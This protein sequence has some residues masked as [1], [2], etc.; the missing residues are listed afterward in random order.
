MNLVE[1]IRAGFLNAATQTRLILDDVFAS[2]NSEIIYIP[3][4]YVLWKQAS[5]GHA[6]DIRVYRDNGTLIENCRMKVETD[7]PLY[8]TAQRYAYQQ[9]I[10]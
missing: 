5:S 1:R 2:F 3:N 4:G 6:I 7:E 10:F 8:V 9:R